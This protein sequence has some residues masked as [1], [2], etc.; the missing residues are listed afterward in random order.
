M[1]SARGAS[2]VLL[3]EAFYSDFYRDAGAHAQALPGPVTEALA[4]IAGEGLVAAPL[5]ERA[6]EALYSA[7]AFIDKT[8]IRAVAR[9]THLYADPSGANLFRDSDLI[10]AGNELTIFEFNGARLGVLLGFDAEFPEAFRALVLRGAD[11]ILVALNCVEPDR[12]F[13]GA[14]AKHNSVP[15]A[16]ANRLGFKYIYP[17]EPEMS[18]TKLPIVQDKRGDFLLR[19]RGHS[20]IFAPDGIGREQPGFA[21]RN[22]RAG[23]S[24]RRTRNPGRFSAG[25]M[26]FNGIVQSRRNPSRADDQ[27]IAQRETRRLVLAQ[28]RRRMRVVL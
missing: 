11:V 18:A 12:A 14:M 23:G 5:L 17:S 20:V 7:C 3:P 25:G 27:P 2:V 6:G 10:R 13:L 8:G 21:K 26:H 9:R 4:A 24:A 22:G 1:R 15:V 16:V 19:C 28:T